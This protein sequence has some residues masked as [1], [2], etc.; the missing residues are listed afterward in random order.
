MKEISEGAEAEI[1]DSNFM[2]LDVIVKDRIAKT[3]REPT[4]DERIR[5][6]R[7]KS[8][9]RILSLA[10]E[11][12]AN[13]P[14]V[15]MIS[16]N[17]ISMSKLRG[18]TLN[19]IMQNGKINSNVM[20]EAGKQLAKLHSLDIIHGDYT[21]ANILVD[22]SNISIID[23]GLGEITNSIEERA[24]DILLMRRSIS[25]SLYSVFVKSYSKHYKNAKAVLNRL[26]EIEKRGRYQT[27]T[28]L[29]K[30]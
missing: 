16:K 7:T 24:L 10:S 27:R 22:G 14:K 2:G 25:K 3:Y 1:Y 11:N 26:A 17:Q 30:A 20:I 13:V 28:L 29:S 6:Q 19:L 18:K 23:F 21:P 8:E 12:G 9:A 4:L 5:E 15:F